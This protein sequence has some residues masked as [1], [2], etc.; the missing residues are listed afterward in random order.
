MTVH[1]P[2][3]KRATRDHRI[4]EARFQQAADQGR[5]S[6]DAPILC[7]CAAVVSS[8]TWDRH[9]GLMSPQEHGA[10][11]GRARGRSA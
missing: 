9:R 1:I 11:G 5:P 3:S 8:G 7:T 6:S 2:E 4:V 10:M